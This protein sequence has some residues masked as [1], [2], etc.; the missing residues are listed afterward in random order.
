M[1]LLLMLILDECRF[2]SVVNEYDRLRAASSIFSG[3]EICL[4]YDG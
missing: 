1:L 3:K 2:F 4:N